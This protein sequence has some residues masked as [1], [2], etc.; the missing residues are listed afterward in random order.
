MKKKG[1]IYRITMLVGLGI[2]GV[3]M[4]DGV[5]YSRFKKEARNQEINE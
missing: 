3:Q 1:L 5:N 4:T 2:I